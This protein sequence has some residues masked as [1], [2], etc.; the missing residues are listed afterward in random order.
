VC[1][2]YPLRVLRLCSFA[3]MDLGENVKMNLCGF[4]E[5]EMCVFFSRFRG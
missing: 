5:I 4:E 1:G 2:G 3:K